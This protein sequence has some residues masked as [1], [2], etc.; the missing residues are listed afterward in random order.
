MNQRGI[1][2]L[3]LLITMIVLGC[4]T[5]PARRA[6]NPLIQDLEREMAQGMAQRG[7]RAQF[8]RYHAYSSG[9]IEATAGANTWRDKTGNCRLPWFDH[10]LRHQLHAPAEAEEFSRELHEAIR[11]E[12]NGYGRAVALAAGKI[13]TQPRVQ[14]RTPSDSLKETLARC[15]RWYDRAVAPLTAEERQELH[16]KLYEITTSQIEGH[17]H[18]FRDKDVGRRVCDLIGK[19][20]HQA[21]FGAALDLS[22]LVDRDW[23]KNSREL[24]GD[25]FIET[26][27]GQILVGGEGDNVYDLDQ[28]TNVA[29]IVDLGGNDTYREGAVGFARP[30]L[31]IVDVAGDDHYHGEK[32]GIQGGAVG[33]IS[34]LVDVAG[35]DTYKAQDVAQGACLAGVGIL[36]DR[37]G[38]D[39]YRGMRRN[40][41][42]AMGGLGLLLDRAG[43]DSYHSALYAQGFGG[44]LGIGILDD[45]DGNDHYYAGG[46]WK[47]GYDDTPG[48]DGWSQGVGAGPRGIAN[49]GVGV[50]LDGGGDDVYEADYFS[51]GGGYWFAVGI[52]RD[53]GGNDKRLGATRLAYDGTEREEKI[54]LRWGVC[55]QAHYGLGFLIDDSGDDEYGG[56]IVGLGFSW[57]IGVAALLDFDGNDTY[58]LSN[59]ARGEQAALGILYDRGGNDAYG[60][61]SYGA[62]STNITYHPLP[63]CGGNFSF[64]INLGGTNTYGGKP[65]EASTVEH[66]SPYGFFIDR[67]A[68]S[69]NP[70]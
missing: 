1:P 7:I 19:L 8:D 60:G 21:F 37:A 48:Y 63:E 3:A 28:L 14:A 42:S 6:S 50:L 64:A 38:D 29:M 22:V 11:K 70:E 65:P 56:D 41:G 36:I 59:G 4:V 53:F 2:V 26:E 44:P 52:A 15:R 39:T 17:S 9:R 5:N 58:K 43:N 66:G 46:K 20:D 67:G 47:D 55:F 61:T 31:I 32:P 34:M 49:G 68:I 62:A 30:V 23:Q 69:L 45:L 27:T 57:D 35:N 33:G 12:R 40:Q 54:F 16:E 24:R 25:S 10:L 18:S 13:G 51:H